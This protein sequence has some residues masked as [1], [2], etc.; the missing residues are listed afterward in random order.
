MKKYL[1][2]FFLLSVLAVQ[3]TAQVK[4]RGNPTVIQVTV[5]DANTRNNLSEGTMVE[6]LSKDSV[7][8]MAAAP[9]RDIFGGPA[10]YFAA[11]KPPS[12]TGEY[13]IRVTHEDYETETRRIV[14]KEGKPIKNQRFD[15]KRKPKEGKLGTAVVR[16][17]KI[18]FYHKGDTLVYNADAFNLAEG[19]MLDALIEQLPGVELKRDGRILV[20][21]RQVESLLLNGKAFF[22]GQHSIMLENLPSYMV[23]HVKVYEKQSES[24]EWMGH[25]DE[26]PAFVMDV[27]LKREYSIGWTAN[28]QVGGGTEDRWLGRLFALR[29]T[30][31]SRLMA[32]ANANNTNETRKPGNNGDWWPGDVTGQT[33]VKTGGFDYLVMDKRN[34]FEVNGSVEASH[35]DGKSETHQTV[36]NFMPGGSNTFARRWFAGKNENT[37]VSTRHSWQLKLRNERTGSR[38][39]LRLNPDFSYSKYDNWS[40]NLSGEFRLDPSEY[41]GLRDSMG[42]PEI[43]ARLA[44]LLVNRVRNEQLS[45]GHSYSGGVAFAFSHSKW[46]NMDFSVKAS[47]QANE[48]HDLYRLDYTTG[49]ASD[50]RRRYYDRPANSLSANGRIGYTW[51]IS[52]DFVWTLSPNLYYSYSHYSQDNVLYRLDAL[53]EMADAPLGALPSTREALLSTLD[54]V[55]SYLQTQDNHTVTLSLAGRRDVDILDSVTFQRDEKLRFSWDPRL[56]IQRQQLAFEGQVHKR[57]QRT[58]VLPYLK[59]GF[60]RV[61]PGNKHEINGSVTFSQS[62]PSLF[63]GL[64]IR[65]DSDPLNVRDWGVDLQRTNTYSLYFSYRRNSGLKPGQ[66]LNAQ[67]DFSAYQNSVATGYTYDSQTGV[68]TY[69]PENVNGNW[70]AS[71]SGSFATPLDKEKRLMLTFSPGHTVNHSVDLVAL[72]GAARTSRSVVLTNTLHAPIKL[73]YS[74][75]KWRVGFSFDSWWNRATSH[76]PG[77]E[78]VNGAD[79]SAGLSAKAQLPWNM[80]LATDFSYIWRYGY[81][82][83]SMNTRDLVWNAQLSKSILKGNLTFTLI[84]FDILGQLSQVNYS[85][86]AQGRIEQWRNVIPS[87]GM[88]RITYRLSKQPKQR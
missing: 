43:G 66:M 24:S 45:H 10:S 67:A 83:E 65:L 18:K 35:T 78:T 48:S 64:G 38:A 26:R 16:A 84:G 62:L 59:L 4:I 50:Q 14:L 40:H 69:S 72:D 63:Y 29:F 55:N 19:S 27:R 2:L 20:N 34:R 70:Y 71:L 13:I 49:A 31:Q 46:Y 57:P 9:V 85:L 82:D 79:M 53:E 47:R 3:L 75:D 77:F 22:N 68:R 32:F 37:S 7:L 42:S 44:Q 86:N 1:L 51:D 11:L 36:E 60:T 28:A 21:G 74:R 33:T 73:D 17:T 6:L 39:I 76:R 54:E 12:R 30:P 58:A 41:V 25:K 81:S 87:Y 23:K 56:I 61:T 52:G 15:L 8:I 80:E 5:M 88:L